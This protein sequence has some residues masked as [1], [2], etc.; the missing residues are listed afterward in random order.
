MRHA[1]ITEAKN[2][3][4]ALI[5]RV[6]AGET[7]VITERGRPIARLGP[8]VQAKDPEGRLARLARAGVVRLPTARPPLELI[9][10]DGPVLAPGASAVAA[11]IEERRE[12]R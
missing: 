8:A 4:S 10:R 11:V 1:T 9:S 2:G 3:L 12:G 7:V 6:R 5:D